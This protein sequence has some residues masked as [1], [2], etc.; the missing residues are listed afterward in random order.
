MTRIFT[1]TTCA[2]VLGANAALAQALPPGRYELDSCSGNPYSDGEMVLNGMQ[3]V[4][5]ESACNLSGPE[6]VRGMAG[7]YLY[8]A[9]C[10]G[11]GETWTA[12][13]MIMPGWDNEVVFVQENW[14]GVYAYCGPV[15]M[16]APAPAPVPTPAPT[17]PGTATK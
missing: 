17:T 6:A 16:P 9:Q 11:E 5:Y 12:R 4:F 15:T 1:F 7:A 14:A 13:Y 10:S 3:I 8:D 2:L